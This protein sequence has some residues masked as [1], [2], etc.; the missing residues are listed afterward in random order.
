MADSAS[1]TNNTL[2]VQYHVEGSEN[3]KRLQTVNGVMYKKIIEYE[4]VISDLTKDLETVF[5]GT[6]TPSAGSNQ[7]I[8][9]TTSGIAVDVSEIRKIG[10]IRNWYEDRHYPCQVLLIF[11]IPI[12]IIATPIYVVMMIDMGLNH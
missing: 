7:S 8:E 2:Y 11:S 3:L 6:V 12:D 9:N 1:Y 4:D 5:V 10:I